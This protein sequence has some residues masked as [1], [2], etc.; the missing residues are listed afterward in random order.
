MPKFFGLGKKAGDQ[1]GNDLSKDGQ[2]IPPTKSINKKKDVK[3]KKHKLKKGVIDGYTEEETVV[4]AELLTSRISYKDLL[5]GQTFL[6]AIRKVK[7]YSLIL[8]LPFHM[9]AEVSI[10]ELSEELNDRIAME[11]DDFELSVKDLYQMGQLLPCSILTATNDPSL[12]LPT[13]SC[14][15]NL[16]NKS[17]RPEMIAKDML[18]YGAVK[19][20][21][22][23][24]YLISL[25]VEEL[26]GMLLKST[27]PEGMSLSVGKCLYCA[28][29][30]YSPESQVLTLSANPKHL[31]KTSVSKASLSLETLIPGQRVTGFFD[32]HEK[33]H[34]NDQHK[35]II[36]SMRFGDFLG[37]VPLSHIPP[38]ERNEIQKKAKSSL[39]SRVLFVTS[40]NLGLTRLPHLL[41]LQSFKFQNPPEFGKLLTANCKTPSFP[42]KFN[43]YVTIPDCSYTTVSDSPLTR[44]EHN[45]KVVGYDFL[46]AAVL[47]STRS[48]I[49]NDPFIAS[50]AKFIGSLVECQIESVASDVVTVRIGDKHTAEC[51]SMHFQDNPNHIE[52]TSLFKAGTT[53]SARVLSMPRGQL[54]VTFKKT[55]VESTYPVV[56][57]Y[58]VAPNTITHAVVYSI[59]GSMVLLEFYNKVRGAVHRRSLSHWDLWE[60]Y[61]HK[62]KPGVPVKCRIISSDP[63]SKRIYASFETDYVPVDQSELNQFLHTT[64]QGSV[65][66]IN[67][68]MMIVGVRHNDATYNAIIPLNHLSDHVLLAPLHLLRYR[69]GQNITAFVF[70]ISD[71]N[72]LLTMK[73]SIKDFLIE[74]RYE[75][76]QEGDLIPTFYNPNGQLYFPSQTHSFEYGIYGDRLFYEDPFKFFLPNQTVYARITRA[77]KAKGVHKITLHPDYITSKETMIEFLTSYLQEVE[78]L[79]GKDDSSLKFGATL[80]LQVTSPSPTFLLPSSPDVGV[81]VNSSIPLMPNEWTVGEEAK[82]KLLFIDL[83]RPL[84]EISLIPALIPSGDSS[85]LRSFLIKERERK[86]KQKYL[87]QEKDNRKNNNKKNNKNKRAKTTETDNNEKET[88]LIVPELYEG[89]VLAVR[90]VYCV[91]IFNHKYLGYSPLCNWNNVVS[92]TPRWNVGDHVLVQPLSLYEDGAIVDLRQME[93]RFNVRTSLKELF[94]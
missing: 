55:L 41:K 63:T 89:H 74:N 92:F 17:L 40:E 26:Q 36:L 8:T 23:H 49:L 28:V 65:R 73:K 16:I 69:I 76:I 71:G 33:R 78:L 46:Q 30:S 94:Q 1:Q 21:E 11:G 5:P 15:P 81:Y 90:E 12:E 44:G 57:S 85:D 56:N 77:Q 6:A 80:N 53:R 67:Q 24:G 35:D 27:I 86:Q 14:R 58:N 10:T 79:K 20:E 7:H 13:A 54:Q 2:K 72:L 25:G 18:V 51:S 64:V 43:P 61:T 88:D 70:H 62:L 59:M 9:Q 50:K 91:V 19:S 84:I 39:E 3:N 83:A 68:K 29:T 45:C 22:D 4:P 82:A 66:L 75:H 31:A 47:I 48:R 38:S 87:L 60:F 32:K 37:T 34:K 42:S 93:S 52:P